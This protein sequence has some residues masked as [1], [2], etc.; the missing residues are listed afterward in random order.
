MEHAVNPWPFAAETATA[1]APRCWRWPLAGGRELELGR[2]AVIMGILNVTP[3]SFSDGGRFFDKGAAVDGG[4]RMVAEGAG[5]IDVGG[6]STRPGSDEVPL[7]EELRRVIPTVEAL[8]AGSAVVISVDTYRAE[9]A[10][11]ALAAGADMVN[12][13]SAFRFDEGMLPLL[14]ESGAPAVAMHIQG[15]PRDMQADPHYDDVVGEVRA[16]LKKAVESAESAGVERSRVVLDPGIGFGKTVEHNLELL[17]RLAELR[18]PGC[19]LMVG[20]SRKSFI[21]RVLELD[22]GQRLEGTLAATALAAAAGVDLI[23]VHDV[24]P[25]LRAARLA[26]AVVGRN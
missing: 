8:R 21:G 7:E 10:R 22:V 4:L 5:V 18:V 20:A 25:N 13:I 24:A 15:T 11:R 12:D 19:P 23:R 16:Y 2:G 6:L 1:A 26:E 3:D 17:R 14:A 9:V